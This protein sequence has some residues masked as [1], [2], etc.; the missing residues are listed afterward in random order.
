MVVRLKTKRLI[1]RAFTES[2]REQAVHILRNE[3]ISKT[4][5]LP[6]FQDDAAAGRLFDRI[7][8]NS[9]EEHHFERAI[10]LEEKVIGF[11]NDVEI[12]DRT[13]ELGYAIHPD[14][15]NKG[16][17]TEAL[18]ASIHEL[19]RQGYSSVR[20]GYFEE[21][22]AS[23]RVMEKSGM[24]PISRV[25]SI[26]YRGT[27]HRCLYYEISNPFQKIGQSIFCLPASEQPLS[28]EV[29]LIQGREHTYLFDV[30][31]NL[32]SLH[33]IQSLP[34]PPIAIL[35]HHHA[36]HTGNALKTN[37]EN[38]FVGEFT[39][40]KLGFGTVVTQP[41]TIDDGIF[42]EIIPCPSVHTSG[43]LIL[44]VNREYCL[45][46]DLFFCKPPVSKELARRMVDVLARVDTRFFVVSHSGTENIFDKKTLLLELK[47]EF[48]M[49]ESR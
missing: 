11:V 40:E 31:N 46:G 42:M 5:M 32:Q 21:N 38:I 17:A 30:G 4:F 9:L 47:K 18:T 13:I 14:Y 26:K 22:P 35:S 19:F 24:H 45:I 34:N 2:D 25:D 36:D 27:M 6:D 3:E 1:L 49:E 10:C 12:R 16:Y 28:A 44:N 41:L 7:L 48:E 20:A 33:V 23:G 8:M 43:S 29:Y 37:F 15:Q 39:R